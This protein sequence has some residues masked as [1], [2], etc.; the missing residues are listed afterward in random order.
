MSN[1]MRVVGSLIALVSFGIHALG[2]DDAPAPEGCQAG[3][4]GPG[5]AA[6][7]A[8]ASFV[9]L[10]PRTAEDREQLEAIRLFVVARSLEDQANFRES[11]RLLKQALEK[12]PKSTAVLDRLS[13]LSFALGRMDEGVEYSRKALEL[14]PNETAN[15]MRLVVYYL[16][17]KHDPP[18]AAKLIEETLENPKIDP[19]SGGYILGNRLLGDLYM[20]FLDKVDAAADAYARVVTALD[21]PASLRLSPHDQELILRRDEADSYLKFG[22]VFLKAKR[23][24][25][26][27]LAFRRGLDYDPENAQL[28]RFL[29]ESLLRS[30]QPERALVT[31]EPYLKHQPQGRE[32]YELLGEILKAQ[33]R[34]K[35]LVTQ[36]EEY[37]RAD[38]NNV[39]LQFALVDRYRALG[40]DEDADKL[41]EEIRK[42]QG[43]PQVYG[44]LSAS[45]LKERKTPAL[46][47]VIREAVESQEGLEK[48]KP[49]I[50]AIIAE[51]EYAG[52]VLDEALKQMKAKPESFSPNARRVFAFI[53][54]QSK[55]IDKLVAL[56]R[57][58]LERDPSPQ[59][60]Q[61]LLGDLINNKRYTE[62]ADVLKEMFEAYPAERTVRPPSV[63]RPVL[64]LRQQARSGPERGSGVHQDRPEQRRHP[65]PHRL[66]ARQGR[67]QPGRR[68]PLPA[69]PGQLPQQRG[70]RTACPFRSLGHLCEHGRPG[71]G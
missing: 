18:A 1:P 70:D 56:D 20:E 42:K 22:E 52:E 30:G 33:G 4:P 50:D 40:R 25:M 45:L 6:R 35:D 11:I 64:L 49:Q 36:L 26:A 29:A 71:E 48:V 19:K 27:N 16:R 44:P 31:L 17:E 9:P 51:P 60:Y 41:L 15:L 21:D 13:Q 69:N 5:H 68:R 24:D 62:T 59:A 66:P 28:P 54:S 7:S 53:A 10:H 39:S 46:V 58:K 12:D 3:L 57:E 47:E 67:T 8:P 61:E 14:N 65:V 38:P 63:P 2:A 32:A 55:Q 34:E 37:A 43:D 23:Y